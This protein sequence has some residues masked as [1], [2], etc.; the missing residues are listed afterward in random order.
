MSRERYRKLMNPGIVPDEDDIS[1]VVGD[2]GNPLAQGRRARQVQSVLD[3]Y[4]R[5]MLKRASDR[6]QRLTR[7]QRARAEDEVGRGLTGEMAGEKSGGL[8]AARVQWPL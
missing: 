2:G 3:R 5:R 7:P 4:A 8:A 6:L 1:D